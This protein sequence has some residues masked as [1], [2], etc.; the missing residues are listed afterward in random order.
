MSSLVHK[1]RQQQAAG[2]ADKTQ[3]DK[4]PQQ[5]QKQQQLQPP[6]N[7]LIRRSV[8]FEKFLV[9]AFHIRLACKSE[10]EMCKYY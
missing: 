2:I 3:Q 9:T 6:R 7:G 8:S 5:A 4:S 10:S 1:Q